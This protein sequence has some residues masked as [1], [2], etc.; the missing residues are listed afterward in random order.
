M[1]S[2][3]QHSNNIV[4]LRELGFDVTEYEGDDGYDSWNYDD[5]TDL[6]YEVL[7]TLE[8]QNFKVDK[9]GE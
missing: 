8:E 6:L 9:E 7:S 3:P 2:F 1:S 4:R 5:L